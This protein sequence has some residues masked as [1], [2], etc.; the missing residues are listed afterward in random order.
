MKKIT[1]NLKIKSYPKLC[2]NLLKIVADCM[3]Y[4]LHKKLSILTERLVVALTLKKPGFVENFGR[5]IEVDEDCVIL[6]NGPSLNDTLNSGDLDFI[7]ARKKFS[8]NAMMHSE[9]FQLLKPEYHVFAD[10]F[11]WA[12]DVVEPHKSSFIKINEILSNVD[13]KMKVFMPKAAKDWN[14][15]IDVPEK[16]KNVEIIYIETSMSSTQDEKTKFLSYRQ[17]TSMPRV[18]NVLVACLYLAT[19][20]RF[21][22]V[23][24][25]GADHTWHESIYIRHDNVL[26]YKYGHF[27]DGN[28]EE[29][30]K[31]DYKDIN[32]TN[33]WTMA[34]LFEAF[35]YKYKSYE[36]LE[37]Y[38][39]YMGTKIYNASKI[40]C[41]DAFERINV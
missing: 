7:K 37:K 30:P 20:M 34:E 9:C 26:C 36:E 32:G 2:R 15:F 5:E 16:N 38:S 41:I 18:Q 24:I 3:P 8:V 35:S 12:K 19:N 25:F 27:F 22:N 13:W 14:F 39:A 10:P 11:F 4:F 6:C 28:N 33:P 29:E 21:K 31:P 23:Y 40:S 1:K 17:N